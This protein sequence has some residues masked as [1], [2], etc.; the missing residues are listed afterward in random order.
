[1]AMRESLARKVLSDAS[2]DAEVLV[3][4]VRIVFCALVLTR[5]LA[6]GGADA[7]GGP[8]AALLEVSLLVGGM[9]LSVLGL[10][11]GR[12]RWFGPW[13]LLG[14]VL[15]DAV[16][17]LGTLGSTLW[18]HGPHYTGLLR[19]PDPSALIAVVFVTALR[20]SPRIAWVGTGLNLVGALAL[21]AL[22]FHRNADVITYGASEVALW[23][24]FI[25]SAGA[26][27]AVTCGVARR[28]VLASGAAGQRVRRARSNL[29]AILREHHDVRTVLSAARLRA[30]LLLREAGGQGDSHH[31]QGLAQDLRELWEF[32]E[33]VKSRALGE[34]TMI[35]EASP[36]EVCAALRHAT[37]V[38]QTR[39][40]HVRI[41]LGAVSAESQALRVWI[42]GG[43]RGLAHVMTN[44]L[45]N[46]CEGDGQRGACTVEVSVEPEGRTRRVLLRVSDDGPGFRAAALDATRLTGVSTKQAGSGLGMRLV[47][48]LIE[49]SGGTLRAAN[50]PGGGARVEVMLPTGG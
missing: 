14:S 10:W 15:L 37:A 33:S 45:V 43:E 21:V 8:S 38:V 48:G 35:D 19:M 6:L 42:V 39:Y 29:R 40:A 12:R 46:A 31:A 30:D 41:V 28:L 23:V 27:A 7:E 47:G 50:L 24:I 32:V 49:A 36:V 20:L 13:L 34:L 18:W 1:M 9:A 16:V 25:G 3:S 4:A 5:F 22:D 17:A 2:N 11:A 26:V 44:L